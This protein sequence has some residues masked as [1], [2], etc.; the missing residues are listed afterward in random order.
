MPT[1]E[2]VRHIKNITVRVH[3]RVCFIHEARAPGRV[4]NFETCPELN[5]DEIP[6]TTTTSPG[7]HH[8]NGLGPPPSI[9]NSENV[10]GNYGGIF[11]VTI[12]SFQNTLVCIKLTQD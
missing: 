3:M 9:T 8:H 6:T 5:V 10:L 12:S 7:L 11:S 1:I 2:L 4:Q